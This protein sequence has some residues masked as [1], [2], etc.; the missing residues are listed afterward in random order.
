MEP[1]IIISIIGGLILLLLLVGT[2]LK[3]IR[4]IGQ[5]I[6]KVL[7]GALLL[8]FLNAFGNQIGLHVP[9]N[10]ITSA[11]SG[12]LGLPGLFALVAIQTWVL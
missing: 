12:F 9:I 8:F 4:F 11:I 7:I 3:P 10:F 6:I 2:P 1:I 5:G